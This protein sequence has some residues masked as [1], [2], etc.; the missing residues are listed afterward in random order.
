MA[1]R[2]VVLELPPNVPADR[3]GLDRAIVLLGN[4]VKGE[5]RQSIRA[6]LEGL[7]GSY[8]DAATAAGWKSALKSIRDDEIFE[9]AGGP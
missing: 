3:R 8:P 6:E 1:Q 5:L 9:R 2:E 4:R 7:V